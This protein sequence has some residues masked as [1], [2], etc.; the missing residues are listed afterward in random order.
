MK[1]YACTTIDG[2]G[3]LDN[4]RGCSWKKWFENIRF[5][6]KMKEC[7]DKFNVGF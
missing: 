5:V 1:C 3:F 2:D 4:I 6:P 7:A